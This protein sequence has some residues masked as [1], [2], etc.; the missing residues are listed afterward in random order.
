[1]FTQAIVGNIC[2]LEVATHEGSEFLAVT[3][4]VNDKSGNGC[5]IK[6][7]NAN[8]LLTAFRNGTLVVGQELILTQWEVRINTI[9][10]HY[11]KDGQLIALR[12]P[13][14]NLTNVRAIIGAAPQYLPP[15]SAIPVAMA[16]APA[17]PTLEE[18]PF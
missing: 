6:F 8:G 16:S 10:S 12:Y 4:A 13:Q 2:Y 18:I 15:A 1:M 3:M 11:I 7:N 14:I 9:R 17:V 5:R